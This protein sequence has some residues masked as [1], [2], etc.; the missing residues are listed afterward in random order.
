MRKV[1]VFIMGALLFAPCIMALCCDN[2]PFS[3]LATFYGV[4]LWH[5]PKFSLRVRKFWRNFWRANIEILNK[6]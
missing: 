2:L 3:A 4:I 6:I 1:I 5:S